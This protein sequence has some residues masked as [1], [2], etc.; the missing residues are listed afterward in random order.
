MMVHAKNAFHGVGALPHRSRMVRVFVLGGTG[1]IG[2]AV[3]RELA[4]RGHDVTGLA[5][6]EASASKFRQYGPAALAADIAA[7]ERWTKALPRLDA[8]IHMACDFQSDMAAVDRRLLDALLPALAAQPDRP[9]LVYTGG[10]WLFGA[11][12]GELATEETPFAPLPAF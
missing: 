2:T 3:V 10:C 1:S 7:P 5:R 9:R 12:H 4:A 8:V 6:S 11:T